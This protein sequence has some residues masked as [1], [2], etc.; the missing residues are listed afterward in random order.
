[1]LNV[2]LDLSMEFSMKLHTILMKSG[3]FILYIKGS[4]VIISPKYCLSFSR[5]R[6]YLGGSSLF[7]EIP[8]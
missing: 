5:E 6:F 1:M 3:Q 2:Y 8:I 7:A 4:Q